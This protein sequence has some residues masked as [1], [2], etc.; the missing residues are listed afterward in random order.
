M[1]QYKKDEIKKRIDEAALHIFSERGYEDSS[2]SDIAKMANVSVGNIYRYYKGK[3]EVFYSVVSPDFIEEFKSTLLN[4]ISSGT[5]SSNSDTF[6]LANE[7]YIEFM[8]SNRERMLVIFSGASGTRYQ[9]IKDEIID[10]LIKTVR[11]SYSEKDN[12]EY[13]DDIN[14]NNFEF[15]VRSIYARLIELVSDILMRFNNL[16]EI[17]KSLE[18]IDSYH[19]FGVLE[20]WEKRMSKQNYK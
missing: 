3:D 17:R 4:K 2:I 7:E 15:V 1:V 10:Y 14:D 6:F 19:L 5:L 20:L 13:N 9:S 8:A 16:Y 18:I 11:D 12:G